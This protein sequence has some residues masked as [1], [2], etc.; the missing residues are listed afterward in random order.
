MKSNSLK[1]HI[2]IE[3]DHKVD[4][5]IDILGKL[6]EGLVESFGILAGI[7]ATIGSRDS[8]RWPPPPPD[9]CGDGNSQGGVEL[10]T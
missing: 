5:D 8:R 2:F 4:L 3:F 7:N 9:G 10:S 1:T 6:W